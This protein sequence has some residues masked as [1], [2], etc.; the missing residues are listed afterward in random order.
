[1][2]N[3]MILCPS[4]EVTESSI[5]SEMNYEEGL[6]DLETKKKHILRKY[7]KVKDKL[8]I[9]SI[10]NVKKNYRTFLTQAATEVD[11]EYLPIR[12]KLDEL[13][14]NIQDT[15][16]ENIPDYST[17]RHRDILDQV[18]KKRH[19]NDL[20][21][22]I[23]IRIFDSLS[24]VVLHNA[25]LKHAEMKRTL[26]KVHK[27]LEKL[28]NRI[29]N[30]LD[31]VKNSEEPETDVVNF[32]V[33]KKYFADKLWNFKLAIEDLS[34]KR[35]KLRNTQE[36]LVESIKTLENKVKSYEDDSTDIVKDKEL[37]T[38][39]DKLKFQIQELQK[40]HK[41]IDITKFVRKMNIREV[42]PDYVF[43][44][45]HQAKKIVKQVRLYIESLTQEQDLG[46]K[47]FD[48]IKSLFNEIQK[49]KTKQITIL[50]KSDD[51]VP[52]FNTIKSLEEQTSD[53]KFIKHQIEK[54]THNV[55]TYIPHIK[56]KQP[57]L[58]KYFNDLQT[59]FPD[60]FED[61]KQDKCSQFP[62]SSEDQRQDQCSQFPDSL[63]DQ[64]Q[65]K[66]SQF[67]DSLENQKQDK[68]FQTPHKF[69]LWRDNKYI[70][71]SIAKVSKLISI[72]KGLHNTQS[73][74]FMNSIIECLIGSKLF[75]DTLNLDTTVSNPIIRQ[76]KSLIKSLYSQPTYIDELKTEVAIKY[77]EYT[78]RAPRDAMQFLNHL[79]QELWE[80][81]RVK[82]ESLFKLT[83]KVV[84]TC[85]KCY[86]TS[87]FNDYRYTLS[88]T[89]QKKSTDIQSCLDSF[90]SYAKKSKACEKC[91][92]KWINVHCEN[93]TY[94]SIL[95]LQ[96]NR[97]I[98]YGR[99]IESPVRALENVTLL[100]QCYSLFAVC[101]HEGNL[102]NGHFWSYVKHNDNWYSCNDTEIILQ[103]PFPKINP[104]QVYILFFKKG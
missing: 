32:K 91:K 70:N 41:D 58:V 16:E 10:N 5:I 60:S 49:L 64:K 104:E 28:L 56:P 55:Q 99:K 38:D 25:N 39:I 95:I 94:S 97:S 59:Q 46:V 102:R 7:Q 82:T 53:L 34:K 24:K 84:M 57:K 12:E 1:M 30:Q 2:A 45:L 17:L 62:D 21:K 87:S 98:C 23:H 65:D 61:Q 79:I 22:D 50:C 88:L 73:N 8:S 93:F 63:E 101:C 81:E 43:K 9:T 66:Y 13:I 19:T 69:A 68:C 67:P 90:V 80:V 29:E 103:N 6:G 74:C 89:I 40:R 48:V 47:D 86:N 3:F 52:E 100:G 14:Q 18:F 31:E 77:P 78:E 36:S 20:E 4:D 96:L 72:P 42:T 83:Y 92:G 54:Y 27:R 26:N 75:L 71:P 51:F 37:Q 44:L 33:L 85:A 11:I 76:L 35:V 15:Q